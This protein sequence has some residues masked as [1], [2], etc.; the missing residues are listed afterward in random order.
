MK[1]ERKEI[2]RL[3]KE[4]QDAGARQTK[5]CEIVGISEKTLQRWSQEGN[6]QDGRLEAKH[7]PANKLTESERER[8]ITIANAPEYTDLPLSKIVPKLADKGIYIASESSTT[9]SK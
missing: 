8:M 9:Y 6:Q 3:I 5:A 7:K 4:A 2:L 1:E